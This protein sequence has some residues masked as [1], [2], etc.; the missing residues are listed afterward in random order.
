MRELFGKGAI[1]VVQTLTHPPPSPASAGEGGV[2]VE[3]NAGWYKTL[4][5]LK[6][7]KRRPFLLP[8]SLS[9]ILIRTASVSIAN[10]F[11]TTCIPCDRCPWF[12]SAFSA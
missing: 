9:N 2:W 10:G 11:V 12:N 7:Q 5:F 1:I 4:L 3:L 8:Y 6:L